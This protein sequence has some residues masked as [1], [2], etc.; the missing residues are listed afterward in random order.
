MTATTAQIAAAVKTL[1]TAQITN[2]RIMNIFAGV[3]PAGYTLSLL[4][5]THRGLG[6]CWHIEGGPSYGF[7]LWRPVVKGRGQEI[8]TELITA[9]WLNAGPGTLTHAELATRNA[10]NTLPICPECGQTVL[11]A[12]ASVSSHPG[13][14]RDCC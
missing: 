12:E 5:G 10:A 7:S 11:P 1:G 4:P 14:H 3:L 2:P 13:H 9:A 8:I 6:L